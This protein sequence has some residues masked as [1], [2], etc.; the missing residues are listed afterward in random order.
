LRKKLRKA[1]KAGDK[2]KVRKLRRRLRN[3]GC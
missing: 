2:A 1:K 3:L